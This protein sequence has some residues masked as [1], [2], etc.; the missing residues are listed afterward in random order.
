MESSLNTLALIIMDLKDSEKCAMFLNNSALN[1]IK[2]NLM[3]LSD[4][5]TTLESLKDEGQ[6]LPLQAE[7]YDAD[8]EGIDDRKQR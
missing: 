8:V 7:D 3:K 5:I 2:P 4:G 6:V 1:N